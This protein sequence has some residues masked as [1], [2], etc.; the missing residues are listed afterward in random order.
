MNFFEDDS[1]CSYHA[2][3]DSDNE[4]IFMVMPTKTKQI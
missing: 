4:S 1:F 2:S 3:D